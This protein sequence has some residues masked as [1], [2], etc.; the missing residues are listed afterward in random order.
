MKRF[1]PIILFVA[2]LS[3]IACTKE[4][5]Y[6]AIQPERELSTPEKVEKELTDVLSKNWGSLSDTLSYFGAN[7]L[8]KGK[9]K[10][11]APDGVYYELRVTARDTSCFSADFRIKDIS[12]VVVNSNLF[13]PEISLSAFET[14]IT[15]KAV[16][17]DSSSLS[18][19]KIKVVAPNS[20]LF[21]E[22]SQAV[23]LYEDRLVGFITMEKF[24]NTDYSNGTYLVVHYYD[25]P[26]TFTILDKG[27]IN[28]LK[29]NLPN[30]FK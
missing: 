19:S 26:R 3:F 2:L 5:E 4:T 1:Y 24:E 23:L 14:D 28:L 9:L 16:N 8:S 6:P 15:I 22:N 25:D 10:G 18:V 29:Q 27:F 7:L 11:M 30:V 17:W 12:W 21:K 20:F 13:P